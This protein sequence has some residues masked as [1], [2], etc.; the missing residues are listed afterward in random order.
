MIVLTEERV[1]KTTHQQPALRVFIVG[2]DSMSSDLLASALTRDRRWEAFAIQPSDLL[3]ALKTSKVDILVIEVALKS[4]S[5][6]GLELANAVNRAHPGISIVML[7]N[8]T[9]QELV[10]SAFRAGALGVFSRQEPISE[11]FNCIEHVGKGCIWAG[12]QE[13]ATILEAFRSLPASNLFSANKIEGLTVRELQVVQCAAKGK[14]NKTIAVELRLS[15]HTVKNY[16]FRAFEKLG[17]SSRVELF[18]YLT[19]RGHSFG[20]SRLMQKSPLC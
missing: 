14:T 10:V 4:K 18:F 11:F 3:R 20:L 7:L 9:S 16:L 15:E 13:T 5:G 17:V 6:T 2:R 12:R 1:I 8:Q 19:M